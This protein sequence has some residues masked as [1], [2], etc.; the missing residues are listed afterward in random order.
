MIKTKVK[1]PTTAAAIQAPC[2][3]EREMSFTLETPLG[4]PI[5]EISSDLNEHPLRLTV[6]TKAISSQPRVRFFCDAGMA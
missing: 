2:Q 1:I 3:S 4:K 6:A 5:P